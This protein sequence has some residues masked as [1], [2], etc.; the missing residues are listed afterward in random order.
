[1]PEEQLQDNP[2]FKF[3]KSNNL[4]K[5]D[6][7][8]FLD[9]YSTPEKAKEI[10]GFMLAN[11]L[12]DLDETKFYD[13]YLSSGLKKK[14]QEVSQY[15]SSPTP[16]QSVSPDLEKGK[17]FAEKGFLMKGE[18]TKEQKRISLEPS[19]FGGAPN[20]KVLQEGEEPSALADISGAVA[21]GLLQG[22]VANILS[23]GKRPTEDELGEIAQLQS[24]AQLFPQSKS[25]K[26]YQEKG[27]KGLFKENPLLGAQFV[28]ETMASSLSSLIEA[29]K[30]T[31]PAAVIAGAGVGAPTGVGAMVGAG[32]GLLAGQSAAGYNLSTS[33]DILNSLS[34]NGVDVSDKASLIKAFSDENKMAKIRNTAAKYGVPILIFDA[35]TAGLAGKLGA[36]AIGKSLSK[37]LLAGLGETGI[38]IAGGMGGELS[39]Q[40]ASG[41]KVNWDDIVM[42]GLAEVPGGISE[43]ATGIAIERSKSSSNNKTLATQIATQGVQN[44]TEDA[45]V[46]LNRDLSNNVI[47]PKQYQEG[48]SFVE[49]AFQVYDKI[50]ETVTGENRVKSIELLV[51]R[52][53][54]KQANENLIQQK[55]ASDE[56]YHAGIDE[57]IKANEERIKKI[58][59]EVYDIT[60]KPEKGTKKYTVDGKEVSQ[61]E[62][63]ALQDKPIGTKTLAEPTEI[64]G[65]KVIKRA[66]DAPNGEAVYEV[67]GERFLTADGKELKVA[68]VEL[69]KEEVKPTE[70][71]DVK[72]RKA[73]LQKE[74]DE[75][76]FKPLQIGKSI[77]NKDGS[78]SYEYMSDAEYKDILDRQEARK[79]KI[80]SELKSLEEVKP[81]EIK[82]A[83]K[84][85]QDKF[86]VKNLSDLISF[87]D[88]STGRKK[89]FKLSDLYEQKNWMKRHLPKF[90]GMLKNAKTKS[91]FN[92]VIDDFQRANGGSFNPYELG[93]DKKKSEKIFFD[94]LESLGYYHDSG[95]ITDVML[96]WAK[97]T[98]NGMKVPL[99]DFLQNV[100]LGK[101]FSDEVIKAK[102]SKPKVEEVKPT[103]V[104][105]IEER[106]QLLNQLENTFNLKDRVKGLIDNGIIDNS[107]SIDMGR[108]I[109]IANI[110]G[111]KVPFYRSLS[112]TGG[113]TVDK[114]YPFFG[115]GKNSA[116]DID[117]DWFVKGTLDQNEKNY[118]SPAIAE[119]SK[120]LNSVLNY[121]RS[122]DRSVK[123]NPFVDIGAKPIGEVNK[124]IYGNKDSGIVNDGKGGGQ[125]AIKSFIDK[126]NKAY[127]TEVKPIEIKETIKIKENAIQKPSTREV[128]QRPQEGVRET[129]GERKRVEPS[130]KGE[131]VTKEGKQVKVNEEKVLSSKGLKSAETRKINEEANKIE[132]TDV[133]SAALKYLAN[134]KLSWS[135][136]DEVAGRV[137]RAKLNTGERELKSAEAR[138]RDYVAKKG[139]GESLDKAAHDIWESL[140]ENIPDLDTRDVKNALMDAI[141]EHSSKSEA[142]KALIE[143][144]KEVDIDEQLN[145][146]YERLAEDNPEAMDAEM[147]KLEESMSNLEEDDNYEFDYPEEHINN[148]KSQYEKESETKAEQPT[149]G[150]ERKGDE[151]V[152]GRKGGE[153]V[154]AEE[155][156]AKEF[157]EATAKASKKAKEN[158]KKEFVERNFDNIVEKLKIQIKCPT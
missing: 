56:A 58:D 136:I 3:M 102:E 74:L 144:Y 1:M 6:E 35:A 14:E 111:I 4:T 95:Y 90:E 21:K 66:Q 121:P 150:S 73:E 99:I 126:V 141:R 76:D 38:Q 123:G 49:K 103:E 57:E 7:K 98:Q 77:E 116:K 125:V 33:Q 101:E 113:K 147:A 13:K 17:A 134:A 41:K 32:Y 156:L 27:L 50:P 138:S 75:A 55:Q 11:K 71:K 85:V 92:N 48:L 129:G 67:E 29:S 52:N 105:S 26:V 47:T 143:G 60:K 64:G 19:L 122:L 106:K 36:G 100:D 42:E 137:E 153:N 94:K 23:A 15:V 59:S 112:G 68:K 119:Y 117:L 20:I 132:A 70:V 69:P 91:D 108:P 34:E 154:K 81:T 89:V 97:R 146:Y 139:E 145:K 8:S 149:K 31:V 155:G 128:L 61:E 45:I 127:E 83:E 43:V 114:W 87:D 86:P 152:S 82:N 110:G 51:E 24:D 39:G 16:S 88:P 148:L 9:K 130:I 25:E 135:A 18:G 131:A 53:D 40:L 151:K 46:N 84:Q 2:I 157:K 120:I 5:L 107:Y 140:S 115:F 44:G 124:I 78:F 12:T 93:V 118:N 133:R 65:L 62:F 54:I 63:D 10:H 104:K 79:A 96:E 22:K 158:A 37:K 109:V 28:A 142:A 80:V 30:K 72:Q